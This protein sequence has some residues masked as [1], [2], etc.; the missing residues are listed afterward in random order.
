VARLRFAGTVERV[1][2]QRFGREQTIGALR[3]VRSNS[4]AFGRSKTTK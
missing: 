2:D 3:K 1:V 4:S